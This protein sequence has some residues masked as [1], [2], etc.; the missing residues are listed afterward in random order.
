M[1]DLCVSVLTGVVCFQF[2]QNFCLLV[3]DTAQVLILTTEFAVHLGTSL[4]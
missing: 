3:S 1:I 4:C 2:N